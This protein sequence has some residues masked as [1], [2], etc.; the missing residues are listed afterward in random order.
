PIMHL[1]GY[2]RHH[3]PADEWLAPEE[4]MSSFAIDL[5]AARRLIDQERN[6]P[7]PSPDDLAVDG[8]P[9]LDEVAFWPA[10]LRYTTD[11]EV[12]LPAA[13]GLSE[14]QVLATGLAPLTRLDQW[15]VFTVALPAGGV[16][17]IV[18]RTQH[19]RTLLRGQWVQQAAEHQ[20]DFWLAPTDGA[21]L[22]L[23]MLAAE[24]RGPALRW[25]ELKAIAKA[26]APD[27]REIARRLLLLAPM[28]GDKHVEAEAVTWFAEA[29]SV[30][31]G[32]D[33]S[34]PAVRRAA[35]RLTYGNECFRFATWREED[36]IWVCDGVDSPR[37]PDPLI[38][39]P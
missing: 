26:A 9:L 32:L 30:L 10:H 17:L 24:L 1:Y 35:K 5:A 21:G 36:G 31:G 19:S 39:L 27:R 3:L 28:L 34:V 29:I 6:F 14:D 33:R 22:P 37:N 4:L 13:F 38:G 18:H 25:P 8:S 15:P 20:V 12:D 16:I 7:Y 23:G 11:P 2:H